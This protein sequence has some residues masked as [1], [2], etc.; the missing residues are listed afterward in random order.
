MKMVINACFGGWSINPEIADKYGF[1]RYDE[2]IT[3]EKLI[4]LIE[5]GVDC[6]DEYSKLVVVEI[7]DNATDHRIYDH[8]GCDVVIYVVDGKIHIL[9]H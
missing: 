9:D 8:D 2:D 7:P 1:D 4:E 5:S 3:N 6:S